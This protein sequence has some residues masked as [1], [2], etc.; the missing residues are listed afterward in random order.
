MWYG[1]LQF[2][3]TSILLWIATAV[4]LAAGSYCKQSNSIHFAHVWITAIKFVVTSIAILSTL[5]FYW[6]HKVILKKHNIFFKLFTFK[7][8]IG[9]N[10]FQTVSL[11]A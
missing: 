2:I 7:G 8:V 5:R 4:S 3:P 6:K 1:V 9:L 11:D 10:F